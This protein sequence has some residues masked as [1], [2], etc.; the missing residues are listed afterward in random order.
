MGRVPE[1][2]ERLAFEDRSTCISSFTVE[3]ADLKVPTY[4]PIYLLLIDKDSAA[5]SHP[6]THL[7][8]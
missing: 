4:P 6:P 1:P 8:T 5:L 3:P 7:P 2:L